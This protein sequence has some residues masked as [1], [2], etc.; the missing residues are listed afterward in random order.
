MMRKV[1]IDIPGYIAEGSGK[2]TDQEFAGCM[3]VALGF[4]N[5]LQYYALMARD[6]QF[7]NF[8]V[9]EDYD[10]DLTEVKKMIG[11]FSRRLSK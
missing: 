2:S 9:C 6:L 1:A 8:E 7:L 10:A 5:R 3:S 11:G 4:A